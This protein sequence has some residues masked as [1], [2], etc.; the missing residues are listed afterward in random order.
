MRHI[1]MEGRC[2]VL[3]CNQFVRKRDYPPRMRPEVLFPSLPDEGVVS[4]G[5]SVI[6]SPL[7]VI[8]AGPAFEEEGEVILYAD[9]DLRDIL[10]AKMDFDPVGHYARPDIFSLTVNEKRNEAVSFINVEKPQEPSN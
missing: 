4:R 5:G 7:G 10:R 3:G 6:I 1:A 9:L 8:L 2:F